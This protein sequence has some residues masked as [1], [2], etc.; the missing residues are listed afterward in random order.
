MTLLQLIGNQA[1]PQP[2]S[3]SGSKGSRCPSESAGDPGGRGQKTS[4]HPAGSD[5]PLSRA[6]RPQDAQEEPGQA[7]GKRQTREGAAVKT[8]EG[9]G[10][11]DKSEAAGADSE[12]AALLNAEALQAATTPFAEMVRQLT[13]PSKPTE[14][15]PETSDTVTDFEALVFPMAIVG[16]SIDSSDIVSPSVEAMGS[17]TV[18]G[19][20]AVTVPQTPVSAETGQQT[21]DLQAL[22]PSQ[23]SQN[24]PV[25][26]ADFAAG[27][28]AP[29]VVTTAQSQGPGPE[30]QVAQEGEAAQATPQA[31]SGPDQ[32]AGVPVPLVSSQTVET[33]ASSG[34]AQQAPV[35]LPGAP[36]QQRPSPTRQGAAE[37]ADVIQAMANSTSRPRATVR[38]PV[39][40]LSLP[41]QQANTHAESF[42]VPTDTRIPADGIE[43]V[44]PAS[45]PV[46]AGSAEPALDPAAQIIESL[47][48]QRLASG[49][50]MVVQLTPP[51][52]GTVRL[53]LE[54]SGRDIRGVVEADNARTLAELQQA[55]PPM[56]ERLAEAGVQVRRLEFVLSSDAQQAGTDSSSRDN[57]AAQQQ[58]GDRDA[59]PQGSG[60]SGDGPEGDGAQ[61][62]PNGTRADTVSD[63]AINVWM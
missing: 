61:A 12:R 44:A 33:S 10:R 39:A 8:Q 18:I 36:A 27:A 42:Q 21:G 31:Q 6:A 52:L 19:V 5:K 28:E 47:S 32:Q 2:S 58:A 7:S 30:L 56:I 60:A 26:P 11:T 41:N 38:Q 40:P 25:Q 17:E 29:P 43:A 14:E 16:G 1:V 49:D 51:E 4:A 37:D 62:S 34:E 46:R 9:S 50:R 23:P 57:T 15:A 53:T 22:L 54:G 20:A 24:T 48:L 35:E 55:S 13:E 3:P 45:Q 63:E 59:S